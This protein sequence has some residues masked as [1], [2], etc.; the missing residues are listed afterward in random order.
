MLLPKSFS[1]AEQLMKRCNSLKERSVILKLLISGRRLW[2]TFQSSIHSLYGYLNCSTLLQTLYFS[3][4]T[5]NE[6]YFIQKL[7]S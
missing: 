7:L 2:S 1:L 3:V 5:E 4:H 6:K